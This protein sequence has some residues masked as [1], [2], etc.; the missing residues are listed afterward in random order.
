MIQILLG[1]VV[2]GLLGFGIYTTQ[3]GGVETNED[4]VSSPV[5]QEATMVGDDAIQDAPKQGDMMKDEI[6]SGS[7]DDAAM[8]KD[9]MKDEISSGSEDDAA[10]KKDQMK[11]GDMM[12]DTMSD[13]ES[14]PVVA[15]APAQYVP[16]TT[17]A[18]ATYA[19]QGDVV[20]F[21]RASW[22][23]GC[24]AL[25]ADITKNIESGPAGLT[26]L[27]VDYDAATALRQQYGV[28]TQHTLVQVAADGTLIKKWSG[29]S[30]LASVVIQV[31]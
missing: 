2:V 24:R 28:T 7:E 18:V 22:C 5:Q 31:E 26:I 12:K 29:G 27:D 21:F 16:Y 20:L 1:V 30:T 10:M 17:S 8:K 19:A 11:A 3:Q 4:T 15:S 14:L 6:S 23:P 25:N 13:A 9:Q